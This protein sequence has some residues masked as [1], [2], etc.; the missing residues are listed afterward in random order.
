MTELHGY[1]TDR[2]EREQIELHDQLTG[3]GDDLT[4]LL[5]DGLPDDMEESVLNAAQYYGGLEAN[6]DVIAL[7]KDEEVQKAVA[8]FAAVLAKSIPDFTN[9]EVA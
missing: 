4:E 1:P 8:A 2:E 9:P 3:Y 5:A 6:C 7:F